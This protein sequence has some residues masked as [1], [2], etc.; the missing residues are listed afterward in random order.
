MN[1]FRF[2]KKF[3]QN[4]LKDT[5]IVEKIVNYSDIL[6]DTLVV[7]VGPGR[8]ILT[9]ELSKV[10]KN[11]LC[12]EID[13]E[14]EG[15]LINLQK[16]YDNV[17]VIFGDFLDRD[18]S[19]DVSKYQY[20]HIY[21]VS[22]VPYYITTPIL[23][24]IMNSGINFERIVMMVQQEVGERFVAVPGK[25]VYSSITVYLNY[26]YDVKRL[27]RV[28]RN[29]FIPVPNVDSEVIMFSAKKERLPLKDEN[30][31]F[32]LVRDSFK[33]KRKTLR[34]NLK[35]Y[36]LEKINEVLLQNGFT[37][38][39]RAEEIPVDVFAKISNALS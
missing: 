12:Y 19:S 22:N 34:N 37:L 32:S 5:K 9:K 6:E 35:K 8:G 33:F 13:M 17:D 21:F 11:V 30:A 18:L 23:M 4:F 15:Y 7:E 25:R 14:L 1:D 20:K 31:F 2:K 24:K 36:D 10:A 29:E 26:Y 39:S 28:S 27:F 3:G 16:E 38:N